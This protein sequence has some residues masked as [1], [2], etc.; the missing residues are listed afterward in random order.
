[1]KHLF[2]LAFLFLLPHLVCSQNADDDTSIK[3]YGF[4]RN[5]LYTDT[6]RGVDATAD[7]FYLL[8]LYAGKDE[9]GQDINQDFQANMTA[10]TSRLGLKVSGPLLFG[11]KSSALMEFDFGGIT[12]KYPSVFRIRQ[13]YMKLQWEASALTV[14]QTWHPFWGDAAFP[15]VG[16]LNTG[17]PFQ[18][19]NRSPQVRYDYYIHKNISILGA[20]V[21]EN[22]YTSRGFYELDDD[23]DKTKALRY[24]ALP[25]ITL[26]GKYSSGGFTLGLGAEYKSI[27]PIDILSPDGGTSNY[28]TDI[29]NNSYG[30]VSYANYTK[31]KLY[32]L[33]K[34]IYGQNLTHLTMAGGYGVTSVD[35]NTGAYQYSNYNNYTALF[36]MTYG[37]KWQGG[38]LA[39]IGANLGTSEALINVNGEGPKTAGLFTTVQDMYRLAPSLTLNI[40]NFKFTTEYE[41]TSASYGDDTTAFNYADG[42]YSGTVRVTNHHML[43]MMMYIF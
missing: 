3:C 8:P 4:I 13:A 28:K 2:L 32:L 20:I 17:A 31:D 12:S 9:N 19:F 16:S 14:G 38:F 1:M 23:V 30:L 29:K 27:L 39:G 7:Q 18:A 11:A 37:E 41:M 15:H 6:Y 34:G 21:Y 43:F 40:K 26:M 36:N 22:Q 42:L 10:I 33:I 25:E 5:A 35:P 24:S